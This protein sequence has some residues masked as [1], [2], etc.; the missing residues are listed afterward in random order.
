MKA[1]AHVNPLQIMPADGWWAVYANDDGTY[2]RG[3]LVGFALVE[4]WMSSRDNTVPDEDDVVDR[5][6]RSLAWMGD[7]Y[8][9]IESADN[10][11]GI[12][13]ADEWQDQ[14]TQLSFARLAE[15]FARIQAH[16]KKARTTAEGITSPT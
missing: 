12:V 1:Y 9:D 7:G 8:I 2:S 13:H 15:E 14:D 3:R 5:N 11:L 4:E 16:K 10:L 6:Y